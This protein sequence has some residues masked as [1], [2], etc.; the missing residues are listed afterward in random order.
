MLPLAGSAAVPFT[1]LVTALVPPP[2]STAPLS[3]PLHIETF[4]EGVPAYLLHSS[5]LSGRQWKRLAKRLADLGFAAIVPDLTG[6][7]ASP[8]WPEPT[9]FSYRDEIDRFVR[10]LQAGPPAHIVGHSYGGLVA[11]LAALEAPDAV[12]SLVLYEPVAMG[13]LDPVAD[14]D[15]KAQLTKIEVPWGTSAADHEHWLRSFVEYWGGEGGWDALREEARAEFRR[16]GW[17][18]KEEVITLGEDATSASAYGV[19]TCPVTLITG[20]LSPLAAGRVV[21]H[22][23]KAVPHAKVVVLP[24]VGHM[25][26]LTHADVVNEIVVDALKAAAAR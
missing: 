4:G 9:P 17:V 21:A 8:P 1:V 16:V 23:G 25:G 20:A 13:I 26:P 15:A 19:L 24:G 10:T 22:L 3:S 5:G 12:R 2:A 6:H 7:G 11:I 14:A 18:L